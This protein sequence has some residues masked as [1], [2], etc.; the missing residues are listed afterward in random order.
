LISSDDPIET[1]ERQAKI[2]LNLRKEFKFNVID[3]AKLLALVM[4]LSDD[5]LKLKQNVNLEA[6]NEKKAARFFQMNQKFPL[7]LQTIN[8][9]YAFDRNATSILTQSRLKSYDEIVLKE[10]KLTGYLGTN[11]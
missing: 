5:Y 2:Q 9:N 10:Q 8:C 3:A 11:S 7:E 1:Q 4:L 6:E